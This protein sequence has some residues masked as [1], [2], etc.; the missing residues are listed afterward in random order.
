MGMAC[1]ASGGELA[2]VGVDRKVLVWDVD[3]AYCTHYFKDA[4]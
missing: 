1:N 4:S 3:E 2:T